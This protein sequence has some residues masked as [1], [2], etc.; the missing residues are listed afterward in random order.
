MAL[1]GEVMNEPQSKN[2]MVTHQDVERVLAIGRLLLPVLTPEELDIL[3]SQLLSNQI[4]KRGPPNRINGKQVTLA[5][6]D[7]GM[8]LT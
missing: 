4:Q 1:D 3:Q 7:G 6:L 2:A 5:S 8:R